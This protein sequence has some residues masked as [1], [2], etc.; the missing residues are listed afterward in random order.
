MNRVVQWTC[1]ICILG[2]ALYR[3]TTRPRVSTGIQA[4]FMRCDLDGDGRI[5][6]QEFH[7]QASHLDKLSF[8][9]LNQDKE[10]DMK[11]LEHLLRDMN[12]E[13]YYQAPE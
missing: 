6:S 1:T 9:D 5:S 7:R 8:Y 10:I 11:E 12:P 4:W 13:W 2:I 3:W